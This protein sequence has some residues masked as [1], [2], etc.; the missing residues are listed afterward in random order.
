MTERD[1]L[2]E[3]KLLVRS[4]YGLI[5]VDTPEEDRL[6]SLIRHL[7]DQ[8]GLPLFVWTRTRG[9]SRD[10]EPQPIYGTQSASAALSHIAASRL[11]AIYQFRGVGPDLENATILEQI[12]ELARHFTR[13]AGA[14]VMTG[15]GARPP[16]ALR[17]FSAL[18]S[19]PPPRIEDYRI[20]L[21]RILRDTAERTKID[22][23]ISNEDLTRLLTNLK[24]LTLMEA[25]KI[26][27]KALIV[28][29]A[30]TADDIRRVIEA[31]KEIVEKDGLLEYYPVETTLAGIA[32]LAGL[33]EWL[34]KRKMLIERPGE[35]KAFG[36]SFPKGVL[37]TGV[38]GTGK[39]LSAKAVAME[40]GLP[41]LKL[42]PSRLYNKYVGETER[43]FAS[44]MATAEK[45]APVVLWVDEIEKAFAS[46]GTD[47][48]GGVSTRVLGSFLSWMQERSGDVFVVATAND[49]TKLPPE[50]LR[51][52]RFDEI[53]FVDLPDGTARVALFT[54]HLTRRGRLPEAFD[55][56]A[57]SRATEGFSGADVEQ[58]IISALY[59]TF[60]ESA[61]LTTR[62]LL[63][64]AASTLPLSRTMPE[65]IDELRAW[66]EGRTVRAN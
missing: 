48:D 18:V 26:L 50:L 34:G 25:E 57:L 7:A 61:D 41:L 19:L 63:E 40:W 38:P 42:D 64:E 36:L 66:A 59:S 21:G 43:N 15:P 37:L 56:E 14:L 16:E 31:K 6:E 62:V 20:L 3:L 9:L 29:G 23:N 55:L 47:Q 35:A 1:P 52:G 39:S 27:T 17:L 60:A 65:K 10:T 51:K 45:M 44:A 8:L 22:I 33:K 53:F 12:R 5:F 49:V 13:A 32:D 11:G 24:G 54:I 30:L 46:G 58:V 28:D 2:E 4:R